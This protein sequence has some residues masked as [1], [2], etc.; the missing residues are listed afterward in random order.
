MGGRFGVS[1]RPLQANILRNIGHSIRFGDR[2]GNNNV[3]HPSALTTLKRYVAFLQL[4]YVPV[5]AGDFDRAP[6]YAGR[7]F[8]PGML[9]AA[10][11]GW[12]FHLL[13]LVL[14]S[15]NKLLRSF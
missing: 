12:N 4:W 3:V 2:P 15:T 13:A 7:N 5:A 9:T 10:Y 11:D 8:R 6:Q 1:L 14:R